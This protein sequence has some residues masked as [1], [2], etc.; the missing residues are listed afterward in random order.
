MSREA[1][2]ER[3][4]R[5]LATDT[6]PAKVLV[7]GLLANAPIAAGFVLAPLL[8]RGDP[9]AGRAFVPYV[10]WLTPAPALAALW[11]WRAK[12]DR[13][14]HRAARMGVVLAATALL[15]WAV[16]LVLWLRT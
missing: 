3:R 6:T 7:L 15:L 5:A 16:L 2:I 1:R 10:L 8:A 9:A 14:S 4:A 12:P 13:R 11:L